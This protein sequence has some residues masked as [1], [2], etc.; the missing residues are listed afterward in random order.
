MWIFRD[1]QPRREG[2]SCGYRPAVVIQ[3]TASLP[4]A[5]TAVVV[6]LTSNL[7]AQKLPG[8]FVVSPTGSNGL[9]LRS[10]VLTSQIRAIDPR[11]IDR[12]I[13]KMSSAD[14]ATLERHLRSL[15]RLP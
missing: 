14:M 13:G 11:R 5:A 2:S 15:L 8:S 4:K 1:R 6:P 7:A 10:V 9:R 3:D 12:T